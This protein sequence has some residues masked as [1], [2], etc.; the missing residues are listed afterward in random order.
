MK[1]TLIKRVNI[2][3]KRR[4]EETLRRDT[5]TETEELLGKKQQRKSGRTRAFW[6]DERRAFLFLN[7]YHVH[8]TL[9]QYYKE[10]VE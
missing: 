5:E 9:Q 2:E 7:L 10:K 8:S 1:M 3:R 6:I 4:K